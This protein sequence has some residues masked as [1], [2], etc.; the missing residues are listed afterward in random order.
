MNFRLYSVTNMY[1]SGIHAGIQTG[2]AIGEMASKYLPTPDTRDNWPRLDYV[3]WATNHKTIITLGGGGHDDLLRLQ[4]Y[5]ETMQANLAWS[6]FKESKSAANECMTCVAVVL[7]E[8][9]W[10]NNVDP[11]KWTPWHS[12]EN[13]FKFIMEL[14][15]MGLAR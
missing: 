4:G 7:P 10:P 8:E 2:H 11:S 15:R 12:D 5:L 14:R 9:L 1:F 3:E 13:L 6:M